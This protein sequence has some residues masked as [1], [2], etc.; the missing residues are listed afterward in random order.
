MKRNY[1]IDFLR[2]VLMQMVVILH[3]LGDGGVLEA[4][5]PFSLTYYAAWLLESFAYCAVNCYV[6]I[7]GYFYIDGRYKISSLATLWLQTITYTLGIMTVA[8]A[9]KPELFYMADF[10]DACF[11]VSRGAYWYLSSYVGL[12]ILIPFLNAAIHAIPEQRMKAMLF[13]FL[14]VFSGYTTVC[15]GDPFTL[16][17]GYSVLWLILLYIVGA[18]I[19]KY[20]WGTRLSVGKTAGLYVG[21]VLLS[22]G[23]KLGT[24]Y[25]GTHFFEASWNGNL[26]LSYLSPTML[27]AAI[28]LFLIFKRLTLSL[29]IEKAVALFAPAAFGVYLIHKQE[30]V[31]GHFIMGKFTGYAQKNAGMMLLSVL[32]TAVLVFAV[33]ILIDL[34]RCRIFKILRI[35]ERLEKWNRISY[36]RDKEST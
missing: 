3:I 7:T 10:L 21:A 15:G 12:F 26:L 8:W 36:N 33:C 24:E 31:T 28:A 22:W 1:G 25:T 17:E 20:G 4:A 23:V 9:I 35:S 27:L 30:Y 29:K 34:V 16:A 2:L 14:L 32:L 5:E 18:C 6:L 11:P 13:F 19:K